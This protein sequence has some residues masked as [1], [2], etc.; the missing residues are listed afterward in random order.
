MSRRSTLRAS[1]ASFA[2]ALAATSAYA[3]DAT[4]P[5]AAGT[6]P[7][8]ASSAPAP[9][10]QW[11]HGAPDHK[12][13]AM[14]WR[15]GLMIPGLGP[16]GKHQVQELKLTADQQAQLKQAQDAQRTLSEARRDG[17]TNQHVLLDQQVAAGKI[18]P[19]ALASAWEANRQQFD[20]Q[21]GQVRD[22]WFAVWDGL[23][24]AQRAQVVG[25]VKARE[26]KMQAMRE[27]HQEHKGNMAKPA[28][29]APAAPAN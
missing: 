20:T 23:S 17:M 4:Q 26:A 19:R 14:M 24:D 18:D 7:A 21:A 15:D 11:H 10:H 25:F 22:K 6:S 16:I 8:P 1:V 29:A 28:G 12:H 9:H 5:A 3:A 27:R 2:M 13:M